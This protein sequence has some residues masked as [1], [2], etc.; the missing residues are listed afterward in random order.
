MGFMKDSYYFPHD[1]NAAN[2]QRVLKLRTKFNNAEGYGIY[3]Y[4]LEAMSQE[5][6]GVLDSD[7]MAQLSLSYGLAIE[8]LSAVINYCIEIG[9]FVQDQSGIYSKRMIEH[10]L[11]R[12][13]RSES[14]K[15]GAY[16]R[17]SDG[18]ANSSAIGSAYAKERKGKERKEKINTKEKVFDSFGNHFTPRK[19]SGMSTVAEALR[20]KGLY[21]N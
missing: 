17:W 13:E 21:G 20:E 1:C 15:R 12:K 8:Q 18:S 3:F 16:S 19:G 2:D 10:K 4:I 7:C 11:F 5:E 14:G 6:D 9:L